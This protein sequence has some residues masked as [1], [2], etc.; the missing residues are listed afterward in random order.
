MRSPYLS[1]DQLLGT[2]ICE[3]MPWASL[4]VSRTVSAQPETD[5]ARSRSSL[6]AASEGN[7]QRWWT[8][9]SGPTWVNQAPA[10]SY[11]RDTKG[12]GSV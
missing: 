5:Q 7:A 4:T 2:R 10:G 8:V 1:G 12:S 11:R 6:R 9:W 3:L